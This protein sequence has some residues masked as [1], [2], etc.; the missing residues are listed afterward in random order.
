MAYGKRRFKARYPERRGVESHVFFRVR[1]R[2]VVCGYDFYRAVGNPPY[3]SLH[4]LPGTQRRAHFIICV[5][6]GETFVRKR[7]MVRRRLRRDARAALFRPADNVHRQR[8]RYVLQM[9]VA[10]RVMRQNH[11]A[12]HYYVLRRRG[13][14]AEPEPNRPLALVHLPRARE[15]RLLAVVH[16]EQTEHLGVNHG[17]AH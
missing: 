7:K 5:V 10:L 8:A 9:Y 4:V 2:R 3:Q 13:P 11:V 16:H 14:A 17:V 1:V 12:R 15:R 6:S